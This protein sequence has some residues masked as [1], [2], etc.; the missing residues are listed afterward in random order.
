MLLLRLD[1]HREACVCTI[2][3]SA[4]PAATWS[5]GPNGLAGHSLADAVIPRVG[6]VKHPRLVNGDRLGG[7]EAGD[8]ADT[9]GLP[10]SREGPAHGGHFPSRADAADRM[11]ARI[12]DEDDPARRHGDA[13]GFGEPRIRTLPV[14]GPRR[15]RPGWVAGC[16]TEQA[17]RPCSAAG[18][19]RLEYWNRLRAPGWPYFLR[20]F[21]RASR[22]RNPARFKVGR[23]SGSAVMSARATP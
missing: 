3:C 2:D 20:S 16:W 5:V 6:D 14:G 23:R 7:V 1:G 13:D 21:L 12:G 18:G 8:G 4:G 10:R 9:V 15:A 19:Q 22:V 11:G 17:P